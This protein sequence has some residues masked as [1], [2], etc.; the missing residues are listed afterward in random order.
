MLARGSTAA[1]FDVV[2]EN[3]GPVYEKQIT[4]QYL[5]FLPLNT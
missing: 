4:A 1:V 3:V 5:I 2:L